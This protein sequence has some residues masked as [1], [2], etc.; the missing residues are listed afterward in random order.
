M[1]SICNKTHQEIAQSTFSGSHLIVQER[2]QKH[3]GRESKN[4]KDMYIR[5]GLQCTRGG[6]QKPGLSGCKKRVLK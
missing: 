3:K 5:P 1:V 4:D 6:L 2:S